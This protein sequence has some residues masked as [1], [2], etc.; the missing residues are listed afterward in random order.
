MQTKGNNIKDIS[1]RI[2][3]AILADNILDKEKLPEKI[4]TILSAY[5][6]LYDRP[7]NYD[8]IKTDA[9][10]LQRRVEEKEVEISF[11]RHHMRK[12]VPAG[13]I[14]AYYDMLDIRLKDQGFKKG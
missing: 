12:I 11:W 9:G 2:S 10:I 8:N 14:Q 7:I 1:K 5:F 6:V 4:K 3:D 13:G